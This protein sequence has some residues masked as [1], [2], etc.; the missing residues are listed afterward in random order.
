[1]RRGDGDIIPENYL[2]GVAPE[3]VSECECLI[4]LKEFLI[5]TTSYLRHLGPNDFVFRLVDKDKYIWILEDLK[6]CLSEATFTDPFKQ[7]FQVF[8]STVISL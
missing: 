2:I 4:D 8:S 1:M 5:R 7:L 3:D 6:R